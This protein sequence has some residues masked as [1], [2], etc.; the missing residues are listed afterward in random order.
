MLLALYVVFMLAVLLQPEPQFASDGVDRLLRLFWQG[1]VPKEM[2]TP[3]RVEA[4]VNA[5]LFVPPAA[6]A[7]L[8]FHR[9][10]WSEVVVAG[11]ASSLAVEL[12]QGLFLAARSAQAIDVVTNTA[13][14]LA[15][16]LVGL[17]IKVA[18]ESAVRHRRRTTH[19]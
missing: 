16:A 7:V 8:A 11:F 12:I 3:V 2:A 18:V 1:G 9:P 10:R 6:L 15:G 13:G 4:L 14:T 5:A 17:A 19:S